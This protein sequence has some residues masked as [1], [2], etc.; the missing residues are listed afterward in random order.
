MKILFIEDNDGFAQD[1]EPV[2]RAIPGITD[3]LHVTD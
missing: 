2:L 3:V 1:L